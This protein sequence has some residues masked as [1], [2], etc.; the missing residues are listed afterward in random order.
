MIADLWCKNALTCCTPV[1]GTQVAVST[2]YRRID[3]RAAHTSICG[4]Q[5]GI[6]A[7]NLVVEAL[8]IQTLVNCAGVAVVL[9]A[10]LC[11]GTRAANARVAGAG[12]IIITNNGHIDA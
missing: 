5:V 10:Q 6:I 3:T 8:R 2:S 11:K 1:G 7:D 4:T 9:I 12:V